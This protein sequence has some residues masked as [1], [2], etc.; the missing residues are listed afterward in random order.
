[1]DLKWH[2]YK[3]IS[4][5]TLDMQFDVGFTLLEEIQSLPD[6]PD[7]PYNSIG[8]YSKS[9]FHTYP[10]GGGNFFLYEW[11][12]IIKGIWANLIKMSATLGIIVLFKAKVRAIFKVFTCSRYFYKQSKKDEKVLVIL[13][14]FLN[15]ENRLSEGYSWASENE[16]SEHKTKQFQLYALILI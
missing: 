16:E 5:Q 2:E 9:K 11:I 14:G 15:H 4:I 6:L 7:S 13:T 12:S 8:A 3:P 1:M 10:T